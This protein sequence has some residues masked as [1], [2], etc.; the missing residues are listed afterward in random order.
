MD[1]DAFDDDD[2][3]P[4][5]KAGSDPMLPTSSVTS[6]AMSESAVYNDAVFNTSAS[7]S[8]VLGG[9]QTPTV[10]ELVAAKSSFHFPFSW[11]A[12][13]VFFIS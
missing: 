5:L 10:G 6:A 1:D 11:L 9:L 2:D 4:L 12:R 3:N 13:R 7:A 8:A